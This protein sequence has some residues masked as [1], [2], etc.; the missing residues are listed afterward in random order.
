MSFKFF[1][2]GSQI[3]W[4]VAKIRLQKANFFVAPHFEMSTSLEP[5]S[6]APENR[7]NPPPKKGLSLNHHFFKVIFGQFQAFHLKNNG[8]PEIF[9]HAAPFNKVS[10]IDRCLRS[11][12]L[13]GNFEDDWEGFPE[14]TRVS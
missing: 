10:S 14:V 5:T 13:Y 7:P 4:C 2:L 9:F 1:M 8:I 11:G 12:Q 6:L 3:H